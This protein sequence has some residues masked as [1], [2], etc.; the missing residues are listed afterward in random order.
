MDDVADFLD[1]FNTKMSAP[2]KYPVK[3]RISVPTAVNILILLAIPV[4]LT[5]A[6]IIVLVGGEYETVSMTGNQDNYNQNITLWYQRFVPGHAN[7]TF[8]AWE[9]DQTTISAG[10]RKLPTL[11]NCSP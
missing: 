7:R 1:L 11:Q 8:G 4:Y 10:D 5:A 3:R 2:W 6:I 9:C